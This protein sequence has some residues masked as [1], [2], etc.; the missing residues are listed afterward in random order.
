MRDGIRLQNRDIELLMF[1]GKY[2]IISLDNTR[3]IYDTVTYQEKRIVNLVKHNYI[4][5][6]KHRYVTLGT[7]GKEYLLENGFEIRNHC[8]NE[9]NVE[10]L[11]VISDIASSLIQDNLNFV[12]SWNMKKEDEPTTHSRRYIGKLEYNEVNEFLVYAIYDGKDDKYIKSIYY[13]I[14]KENGY[15][16]SMIFT[17]DINKIVLHEKGFYFGNNN[18]ILVPYNE[19]GKFLIRNN[20]EIRHSIYLR[21]KEMYA[22]EL[23]DIEF[24]DLKIDDDNYVVIMPLINMETL[25][26]LYC[27]FDVNENYKNIYIFGLEEYEN[28]IRTF[29]PKCEY[30]SL[31]REKL[32]ELLL[33]YREVGGEENEVI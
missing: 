32:N 8:R 7:K 20:Y 12:P 5:R 16:D 11:L 29:L 25:A 9:N 3:Y 13:D 15:T 23:S 19:Y 4:R 10:R 26:R 1:L 33:K 30:K 31:S 22:V 27:Y 17:N 2:K 24:A 21:I 18:T 6:L 28:A 14:R